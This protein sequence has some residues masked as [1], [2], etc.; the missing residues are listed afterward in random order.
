MTVDGSQAVLTFDHA[1][2]LTVGKFSMAGAD[3]SV[4]TGISSAS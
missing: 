1:D 3:K 4:R 2:G